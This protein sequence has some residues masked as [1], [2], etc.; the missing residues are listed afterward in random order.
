[1]VLVLRLL[2]L[3]RPL[4]QSAYDNLLGS[5][6]GRSPTRKRIKKGNGLLWVGLTILEEFLISLIRFA[7]IET[8]TYRRNGCRGLCS[9]GQESFA[10]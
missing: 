3:L 1:M 7:E 8:G 9:V 5:C 6:F 10:G 4:R 2:L